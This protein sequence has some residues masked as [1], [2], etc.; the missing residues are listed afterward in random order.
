M[1]RIWFERGL[2]SIYA[3]LIEGVAVAVGPER[4]NPD[5]DLIAQ[6]GGDS[7]HRFLARPIQCVL[8]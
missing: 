6:A 8:L 5:V 2:P 4:L 7:C 3:H 1:F